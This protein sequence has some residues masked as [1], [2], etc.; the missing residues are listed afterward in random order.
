MTY[1]I[2][3]NDFQRNQ[4][5]AYQLSILVGMDSLVYSV[6]DD[7]TNKLLV[8]KS[9]AFSSGANENSAVGSLKDVLKKEDLLEPLYR[10][11]KIA[12]AHTTSSLVP[13]RLYNEQEKHTYLE[14]L[15]HAPNKIDVAS[16]E[17]SPLKIRAVYGVDKSLVATL[18]SKFPTAHIFGIAAPFLLGCHKLIPE[19]AVETAF[20]CI[21][22]N[23][24]QFALFEKGD[25]LFYNQFS[26]KS[27]S[28]ILYFCLLSFEQYGLD[29]NTVPLYISGQ[30]TKD[31][32][33][34]KLLYRY[35]GQIT[36][37]STPSFIRLGRNASSVDP[38]FLF[39][40]HSLLLC[41]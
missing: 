35:I 19:G 12:L 39:P 3:E 38:N 34:Y 20:A 29:P 25:L 2:I 36:F 24:F 27:S 15:V 13:E 23:T 26:F 22:Q 17:L 21:H 10:R 16:D 41:K 32:E 37:L 1:H 11:V 7:H 5:S 33:I 4:A 30:V 28:D 31:A 18:K 8:L 14:E 9:L 40:L 6:Y